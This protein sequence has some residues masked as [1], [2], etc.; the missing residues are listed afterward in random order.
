PDLAPYFRGCFEIDAEACLFETRGC[1][2]A[3]GIDVD[4][5]QG[6]GA[7]DGYPAARG[8]RNAGVNET[9]NLV[10]KVV[11]IEELTRSAEQLDLVL[12]SGHCPAAIS[13]RSFGRGRVVNEDTRRIGANQIAH[14]PLDRIEILIEKR[15]RRSTLTL[16]K[17][18]PPGFG[19]TFGV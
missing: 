19:E 17:H 14:R 16:C 3:S 2:E 9:M 15:R 5:R 10:L 18:R 7:L 4:R 8:E 12:R 6:L 13:P 11:E 1:R